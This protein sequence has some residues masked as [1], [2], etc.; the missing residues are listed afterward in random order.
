MNFIY[1]NNVLSVNNSQEISAKPLSYIMN[2]KL[3]FK[4]HIV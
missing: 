2:F 1:R 4:T 3:A